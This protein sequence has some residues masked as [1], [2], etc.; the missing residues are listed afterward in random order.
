MHF[1]QLC[2]VKETM[3]NLSL[4]GGLKLFTHRRKLEYVA[5]KAIKCLNFGASMNLFIVLKK[6]TC[7]NIT[8]PAYSIVVLYLSAGS[9][10]SEKWFGKIHDSF[11][12]TFIKHAQFIGDLVNEKTTN[13]NSNAYRK[14]IHCVWLGNSN[15]EKI[16]FHQLRENTKKRKNVHLHLP[17]EHV[18]NMNILREFLEPSNI[19]LVISQI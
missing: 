8:N 14:L 12:K 10:F 4:N 13:V 15:P 6:V 11:L 17:D 2:N 1:W 19:C 18:L 9:D 5:Q 16:S 3:E 7:T